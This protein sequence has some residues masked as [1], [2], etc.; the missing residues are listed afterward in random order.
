MWDNP[1]TRMPTAVMIFEKA[2]LAWGVCP[3]P[4]PTGTHLARFPLPQAVQLLGD[5]GQEQCYLHMVSIGTY[6][7]E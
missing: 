2:G 7:P 4:V 5:C 1:A 3:T 6:I